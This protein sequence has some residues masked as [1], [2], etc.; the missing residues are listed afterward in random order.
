MNRAMTLALSLA[1]LPLLAA[2]AGAIKEAPVP[3]L[4]A[5]WQ[6]P[7]EPGALAAADDFWR[8]FGD[9]Q[10]DALL[11]RARS[12]NADLA[13]AALKLRQA[14][15]A[16]TQ[17]R[18]DQ[19]PDVGVSGKVGSSR[20]LRHNRD[21][22]ESYGVSA[23]LSYELD[24][25]GRLDDLESAARWRET[26]SAADLQGVRISLE[27][28]LA[29]L[30]WQLA[31]NDAELALAEAD[32]GSA[33]Q[34]LALVQSRY[35]AGT[36]SGLDLAQAR[37]THSQAESTL[38]TT[39][40][41]RDATRRALT[42]LLD[43]PPQTALGVMPALPQVQWP[44][45]PAGLPSQLLARRPDLAASQARLAAT[46][47]D[48]EARRKQWLPT[49]SLTGS[50]GST[51]SALADLVANPVAALGLGLTLP[52]VQWNEREVALK[53][54]R[55]DYELAVIAHRQAIHQALREVEDALA[56]RSQLAAD[57]ERLQLQ[58]DEAATAERLT[59]VRYRAGAVALDSWLSAQ[60]TLRAAERALLQHRYRRAANLAT[61]YKALGGAPTGGQMRESDV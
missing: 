30:Y 13:S 5:A 60:E 24:L 11:A 43:V 23:A 2:C 45:V 54:S 27:A 57:S 39:V 3:T 36:V 8:G 50:L 48:T 32:L 21:L 14:G 7:A 37:R 28:N 19:R 55:A 31:L 42:L 52:F 10:L 15:Y 49:L 22:G 29:S 51:S 12:D 20:E 16:L 6:A 34:T 58:R 38:A 56:T 18:L 61:L 41:T 9:P 4:P 26:A 40:A 47:V 59:G 1:A 35:Q 17:T 53:V 33:Q 44:T 46:L 25:W